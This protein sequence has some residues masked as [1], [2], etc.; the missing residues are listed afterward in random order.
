MFQKIATFRVMSP[1]RAVPGAAALTHANDNWINARRAAGSSRIRR[2]VLTCRW[3][4]AGDGKLE[5]RWNIEMAGGTR[6]EEP[7]GGYLI[8]P[9]RWVG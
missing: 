7:G 5:C 8:R 6:A 3:Q 4:P 1:R 9:I 2:P